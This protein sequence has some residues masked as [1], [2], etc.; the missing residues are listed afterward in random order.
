MAFACTCMRLPRRSGSPAPLRTSWWTTSRR[1]TTCWWNAASRLTVRRTSCTRTSRLASRSGWRSSPTAR[2]TR[3]PSCRACLLGDADLDEHAGV[4]MARHGAERPVA[5]GLVD[6]H[7]GLRLGSRLDVH[8]D[9]GLVEGE[10]V[11]RLALVDDGDVRRL[12]RDERQTRRL[13]VDVDGGQR[14]RFRTLDR[15]VDALLLL[16]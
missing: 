5:A 10:V 2:A 13:V 11:R 6:R 7:A 8:V 16:V 3:S 12:T 1:R 14:H 9:L 4:F 15:L